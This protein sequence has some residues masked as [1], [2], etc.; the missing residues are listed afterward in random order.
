MARG[1]DSR[2]EPQDRL[3][4]LYGA[5]VGSVLGGWLAKH[6][7]R[8]GATS[9]VISGRTSRDPTSLLPRT[10]VNMLPIEGNA[11]LIGRSPPTPPQSMDERDAPPGGFEEARRREP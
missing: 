7:W 1:L 6:K 10:R 4:D 3:P 2:R 5:V 11:G 8:V 9:Q